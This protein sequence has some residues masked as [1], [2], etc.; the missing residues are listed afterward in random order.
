MKINYYLRNKFYYFAGVVFLALA[1]I[2][3]ILRGYS[4]PKPFDIS[5]SQKCFDYDIRVVDRWLEHLDR[6]SQIGVAGKNI[7]EI[8]P[9]SD[10]G[11]GIYL[12]SQGAHQ[13][14]ACDVNNL[15]SEVQDSFYRFFY[16][17]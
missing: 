8:G 6:Y 1:K 5:E 2:K 15:M 10:L 12:L 14:N 16:K 11:V 17:S 13:Y 3:N 9:G 7:L 4:S